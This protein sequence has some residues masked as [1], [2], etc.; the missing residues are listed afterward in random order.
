MSKLNWNRNRYAGRP[1]APAIEPKK[2]KAKGGW[3]HI[4]QQPVKVYSAEE[5]AAYLEGRSL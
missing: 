1:T 4:K 3:T 2:T 5:I